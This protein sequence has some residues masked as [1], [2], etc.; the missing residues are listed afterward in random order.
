[1]QPNAWDSDHRK[2]RIPQVKSC[3]GCVTDLKTATAII[4]VLGIVTCPS[5]SWATVRHAFVI[6]VS[7]FI[8]S[9]ADEADVVDINLS[10]VL[11]FGFGA[12]A[13]LG[14]SCLSSKNKTA[15]RTLTTRSSEMGELSSSSL[16][17]IIRWIGWGVLFTDLVFLGFSL[18]FLIK[19][20]RPPDQKALKK[21]MISCVVAMIASF[22]YGMLYVAACLTVGG[23]FPVFEFLFCFVD[24]ITWTYYLI[25][26]NS[27]KNSTYRA[28]NR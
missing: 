23:P 19:I 11:S 16:V 2:Y 26:I 22:M 7:C 21:F 8:T 25:V 6:R 18:H 14:P 15:S 20:F 10:N 4:V 24:L 1:M 12:N 9:S 3:C 13:G 28:E 27:Y 17:K 5:V